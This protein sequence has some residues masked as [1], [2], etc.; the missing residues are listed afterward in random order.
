MEPIDEAVWWMTD[1]EYAIWLK[2]QVRLVGYKDGVLW[3]TNLN[4]NQYFTEL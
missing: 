4:I 2:Y 3:D 1:E